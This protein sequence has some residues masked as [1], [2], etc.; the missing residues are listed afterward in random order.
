M[1]YSQVCFHAILGA[2]LAWELVGLVKSVPIGTVFRSKGQKC[3]NLVRFSGFLALL[4]RF[5]VVVRSRGYT[6]AR[7]DLGVGL[8]WLLG[9]SEGMK[10]KPNIREPNL[11]LNIV[12]NMHQIF[13]KLKAL[14]HSYIHH[15][16]LHILP[17]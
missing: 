12:A 5:V 17:W 11:P 10:P 1:V 4:S 8:G 14:I 13:A 2:R 16:A 6:S 3:T 7:M 15:P 9:G